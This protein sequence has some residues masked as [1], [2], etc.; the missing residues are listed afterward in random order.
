M[1]IKMAWTGLFL[2]FLSLAGTAAAEDCIAFNPDNCRVDLI[3]GNYKIVDGSM[4]LLDFGQEKAEAYK[5]LEIIQHYRLNSQ[6][7]VGRPDPS[8]SYWLAN[9]SAPSGSLAGE[10]CMAF[11]T[12]NCRVDLI[13][14]NYKIVDGSIWLL[15]FGQEKAEAYEALKIIQRYRLNSQCYVGRTPGPP[16]MKYFKSTAVR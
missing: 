3:N 1:R 14:G 9:G 2:L 8:M 10:D 4:W 5:A 15:D 11:N 6:C 7:F 16:S 13:N 12:D